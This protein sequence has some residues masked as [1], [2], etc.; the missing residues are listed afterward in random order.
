MSYQKKLDSLRSVQKLTV[1][2]Y[3]Y[4]YSLLYILMDP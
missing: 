3:D 4:V 1:C 2:Y